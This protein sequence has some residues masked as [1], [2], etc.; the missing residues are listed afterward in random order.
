VG[1]DRDHKPIKT[2]SLASPST[3]YAHDGVLYGQT[4]T[5][6]HGMCCPCHAWS[7]KKADG[8]NRADVALLSTLSDFIGVL[9]H[10]AEVLRVM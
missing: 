4:S 7:A 3:A 10:A 9:N 6:S 5:N 2:L 8:M 1:V